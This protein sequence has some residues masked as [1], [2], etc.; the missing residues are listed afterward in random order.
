MTPSLSLL[1]FVALFWTL[2]ATT[3]V[4]AYRRHDDSMEKLMD[5]VRRS[6]APVLS[7]PQPEEA[8]A[9]DA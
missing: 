8:K 1:L 4:L 5:S 3:A 9:L 6:V 2:P 7:A